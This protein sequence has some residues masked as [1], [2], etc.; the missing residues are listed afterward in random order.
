MEAGLMAPPLAAEKI[1]ALK[2][3]YEAGE[4]HIRDIAV[5][6]RVSSATI[7]KLV[8][9]CGW[10]PRPKSKFQ[11]QN[12]YHKPAAITDDARTRTDDSEVLHAKKTLQRKGW[13]TYGKGPYMCG[14]KWL[15]RDGLLAKAQRYGA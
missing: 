3:A 15:D 9:E 7:A 13:V 14:T 2:A 5:E 4:V 11:K 10:K 8:R 12:S 1:A 6:Y